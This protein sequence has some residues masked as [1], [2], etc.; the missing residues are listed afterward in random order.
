MTGHGLRRRIAAS[1]DKTLEERI[2]AGRPLS[3]VTVDRL[4]FSA[5]N[6]SCPANRGRRGLRAARVLRKIA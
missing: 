2:G 6:A 3:Q 1:P 5:E 4:R